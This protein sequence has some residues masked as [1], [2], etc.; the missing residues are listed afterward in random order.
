MT[1]NTLTARIAGLATLALAALPAAALTTAARAEPPHASVRI[2]DLNL[3]TAAGRSAY[4]HRLDVAARRVCS[5]ET[6][7]NIQAACRAGVRAEV[8]AKLAAKVQYASRS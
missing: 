4:Q 5:D 3:A 2:A 8:N 1:L 7:L 6:T